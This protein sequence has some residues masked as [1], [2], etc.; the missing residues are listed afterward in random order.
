MESLTKIIKQ[1]LTYV[2]VGIMAGAVSFVLSFPLFHYLSRNNPLER[3]KTEIVQ[4]EKQ[5]QYPIRT[6]FLT[7]RYDFNNDGYLSREEVEKV[8]KWMRCEDLH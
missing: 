6:N 7:E 3:I 2:K 1:I 4:K 8:E 5:V